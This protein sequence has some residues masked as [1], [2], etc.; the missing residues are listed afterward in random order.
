MSTLLE[1]QDAI[2][3]SVVERDD[4]AAAGLI[5]GDGLAPDARLNV[6]RNTFISSLTTALRLSFPAV[7]RLVGSEFFETAARVFIEAQPPR[8]AYLDLYGAAFPDFLADFTPAASLAYLPDVARLEWAIGAALHALDGPPLDLTRLSLPGLPE[9]AALVPH[10]ALGLVQAKYPV[11]AIWRAVMAQDDAAM[12]AIDLAAGP[13]W[14]LIERH[15]L[16][17]DVQRLPESSWRF[18]SA[19]CAGWPLQAAIDSVADIDIAAE[20]ATHLA[21]RRFIGIE[22]GGDPV[23]TE[24]HQRWNHDNG[25]SRHA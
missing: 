4:A 3:R 6:Y 19:L 18:L 5:I 1:I 15:D 24:N 16:Q 7:H 22:P 23:S 14:L 20:L 2:Y 10:P 25:F 9:Q 21:A 8:C 11:D 13:V 17:V 12:S